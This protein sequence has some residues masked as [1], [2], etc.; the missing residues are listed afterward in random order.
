MPCWVFQWSNSE[1]A[2]AFWWLK[3]IAARLMIVM[4]AVRCFPFMNDYEKFSEWILLIV[5]MWICNKLMSFE[6]A[7]HSGK[8]RYGTVGDIIEGRLYD[9]WQELG[10]CGQWQ[11]IQVWDCELHQKGVHHFPAASHCSCPPDLSPNL[12][13]LHV[14]ETWGCLRWFVLT[15]IQDNIQ[16]IIGYASLRH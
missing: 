10:H 16:I 14:V 9:Q 2:G 3:S 12:P 1:T 13:R 4:M 15:I 8:R 6:R 5:G 7:H 11:G